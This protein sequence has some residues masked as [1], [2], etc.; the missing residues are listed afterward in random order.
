[1]QKHRPPAIRANQL[2]QALISALAQVIQKEAK[3]RYVKRTT[4]KKDPASI[5]F[6]TQLAKTGPYSKNKKRKKYI[7]NIKTKKISINY[8]PSQTYAKTY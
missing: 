4:V 3:V 8:I 2:T 7:G 6:T 1:M 5:K